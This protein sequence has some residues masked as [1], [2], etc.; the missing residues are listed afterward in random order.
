[1]PIIEERW[2]ASGGQIARSGPYPTQRA[3][4][5][6]MILTAE[7]RQEQHKNRGVDMPYPHDVV[8]WPE[9]SA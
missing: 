2:Y 9:W 5:E 3:A 8:V 4:Y 6:A 7:A 1:M